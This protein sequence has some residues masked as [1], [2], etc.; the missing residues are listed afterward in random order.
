MNPIIIAVALSDSGFPA[1]WLE[2]RKSQA[3]GIYKGASTLLYM[4]ILPADFRRLIHNSDSLLF[5]FVRQNYENLINFRTMLIGLL[6][7]IN[8]S[9]LQ[10]Q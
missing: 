7:Y 2:V 8:D 4:K 3:F 5:R 1:I 9:S 6:K 10:F